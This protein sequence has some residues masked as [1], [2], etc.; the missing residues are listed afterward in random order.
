MA[1][2]KRKLDPAPIIRTLI[3]QLADLIGMQA[4]LMPKITPKELKRLHK[5]AA[6]QG[7]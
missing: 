3:F 6:E 5:A 7:F 2:K 1:T 4:T